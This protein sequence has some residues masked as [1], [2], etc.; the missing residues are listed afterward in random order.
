M[1][2]TPESGSKSVLTTPL[3]PQPLVCRMKTFDALSE[4]FHY[5]LEVVTQAASID[6]GKLLGKTITLSLKGEGG[7]IRHFHGHVVEF[8][9]RTNHRTESTRRPVYRCV[10][11]PWLWLLSLRTNC[12]IFHDSSVV[13]IIKAL[14]AEHGFGDRIDDAL[15]QPCP[16]REYCVQY[17][18]TDLAFVSRLLEQ[19]GIYYYFVHSETEHRLVLVDDPQQLE[20]GITDISDRSVQTF[21]KQQIDT[22]QETHHLRRQAVSLDDY[23]YLMP[24][25]QIAVKLE[26]EEPYAYPKGTQFTYPGGYT[27]P[28]V[29]QNYVKYLLHAQNAA[30]S[31]VS[32]TASVLALAS[33]CTFTTPWSAAGS[34]A[35]S[36]SEHLVV[37]AETEFWFNN[38]DTID[39]LPE[40][41]PLETT[42]VEC[43]CKFTAV[44]KQKPF[45]PERRTPRPV[46]SG[47]QTAKVIAADATA[48][49]GAIH[50]DEYGR[51]L[52]EFP[53][54][55]NAGG[56]T[57]GAVQR[58]CWIRVAQPWAGNA[59][60]MQFIPRVGSEV[61]VSFQDGDPD[62]PL[63]V[64]SVYNGLARAPFALPE[65][66]VSGIKTDR[67]VTGVDAS[68]E[69][70]QLQ[71][72]DAKGKISM[73]SETIAVEA[74]TAARVQGA[75][76]EVS[77][78]VAKIDVG[79]LTQSIGLFCPNALTLQT[80]TAKIELGPTGIAITGILKVNEMV[81]PLP[82][83]PTSIAASAIR[84]AAEAAKLMATDAA[85]GAVT[86]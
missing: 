75:S 62:R 34:E 81:Y 59:W 7:R 16:T 36:A 30:A 73:T 43:T 2:E 5:E 8:S 77:G 53:W 25:K 10:L 56:S 17:N 70:N 47:V 74:K 58:S 46:I 27:E 61:V 31:S 63:I 65:G 60:G 71:F 50:T 85:L 15:T 82:P 80:P 48:Q 41:Q 49:D 55:R 37:R 19:E 40:A 20:P 14:C 32:G 29:G 21:Y 6:P 79:G 83:S 1:A 12:R 69:P 67:G 11:R 39:P 51:V 52:V 54:T 84:L 9:K 42:S 3:A 13:D 33:G 57:T 64:G 35:G 22:W 23:D 26:T 78:G 72:D 38:F 76:V 4:P 44:D 68:G 28:D 86:Q 18:E 66:T 24:T 45:R